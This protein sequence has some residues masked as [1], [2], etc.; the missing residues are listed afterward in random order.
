MGSIDSVYIASTTLKLESTNK[1][2]ITRHHE[3]GL[4]PDLL[5]DS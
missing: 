5:I 2:V 3:G 1:T 4:P